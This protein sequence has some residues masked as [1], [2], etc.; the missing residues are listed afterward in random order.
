MSTPVIIT[1]TFNRWKETRSVG[2]LVLLR[3]CLLSKYKNCLATKTQYICFGG[4]FLSPCGQKSI[5][6]PNVEP[7][8]HLK[9]TSC[10]QNTLF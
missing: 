10:Q 2:T 3:V 9:R 1:L 7:A 5:M 8:K 4:R 6:T